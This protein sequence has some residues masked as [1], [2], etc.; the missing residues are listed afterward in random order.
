MSYYIDHPHTPF[1]HNGLVKTESDFIVRSVE[2]SL[3]RWTLVEAVISVGV[4]PFLA[5][6][7]LTWNLEDTG[8]GVFW[9][10]CAACK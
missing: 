9:L 6:S 2:T 8:I 1:F 7:D 3:G 4:Y 10:H 5:F